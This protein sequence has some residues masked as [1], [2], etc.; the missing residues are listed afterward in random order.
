[1]SSMKGSSS[2]CTPASRV[3]GAHRVE[4]RDA[5]LVGDLRALRRPASAPAPAA[6]ISLSTL[7]AQAAADHQQ[8]AAAPLRPAKRSRRRGQRLDLGA[9]RVAGDH[10]VLRRAARA[11]P[12]KPKAT[13]SATG[14]SALLLSSSDRVGFTQH[15]RLAQQRRHQAAGKADVAAHAEHH[16][17]PDAAQDR[18]QALPEGLQQAQ[19]PP[20]S[21]CSRP[22]PRTPAKVDRVEREAAAAAPAGFPCSAA[23]VPSQLTRQP[24]ARSSRATARPGMMWPPVP[25][26]MIRAQRW[27]GSCAASAHQ[28]AGSR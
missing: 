6:R 2:A 24:R 11:S 7:R 13:R 23:C 15:Q 14:S 10:G 1:M 18:R 22:L 4:L 12:S 20:V 8:R 9:H 26:A 21:V 27:R 16:V 19:R 3:G 5:A 17:G 28:H 25:P